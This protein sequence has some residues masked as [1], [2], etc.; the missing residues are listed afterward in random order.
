MMKSKVFRVE[1]EWA[2][3]GPG[4]GNTGAEFFALNEWSKAVR[5]ANEWRENAFRNGSPAERSAVVF[6]HNSDN[7]RF[8]D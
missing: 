1:D 5:R 4:A 7:I 8:F 2:V 6:V 3:T